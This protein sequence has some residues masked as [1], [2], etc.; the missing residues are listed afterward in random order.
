MRYNIMK[1]IGYCKQFIGILHTNENRWM[2]STKNKELL[3]FYNNQN[4]FNE[5]PLECPQ[6]EY[7]EEIEQVFDE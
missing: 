5:K 4:N 1:D 6:F 2:L 3:N 7:I